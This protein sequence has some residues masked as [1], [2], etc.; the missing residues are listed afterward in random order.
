MKWANEASLKIRKRSK[1]GI[2]RKTA[3]QIPR[4][5]K[6]DLERLRRAMDRSDSRVRD[7]ADDLSPIRPQRVIRDVGG[8]IV[9][10]PPSRIRSAILAEL[11]RRRITRYQ[12]WKIARDDCPTLTQS[13]VYEF[14]RGFRQ[15]GLRYI[16]ALM[17]ALSLRV[18]TMPEA[19]KNR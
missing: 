6:D 18:V 3:A 17:V 15:L 12:L 1:G 11:G 2:V 7:D 8:K 19:P 4:P 13:A 16:E 9:K 5:I 14:L 10:P